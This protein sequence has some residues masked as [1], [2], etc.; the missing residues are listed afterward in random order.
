MIPDATAKE[1]QANKKERSVPL[2]RD[3]DAAVREEYEA[4]K[5]QRTVRA[6]EL[7]IARHP[8]HDLAGEARTDLER[9]AR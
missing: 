1:A 6:L 7:F 3:A 2:A 4:A 8:N 5:Q 9:L